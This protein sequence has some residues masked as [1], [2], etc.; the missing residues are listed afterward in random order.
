MAG[1]DESKLNE[2]IGKMLAALKLPSCTA[3]FSVRFG[4][5]VLINSR[6]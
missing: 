2:L 4:P 5:I 1:I 3:S 6:L